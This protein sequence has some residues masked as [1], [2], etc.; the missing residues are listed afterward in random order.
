MPS[1]PV[2]S[3]VCVGNIMWGSKFKLYVHL[4][5]RRI[6]LENFWKSPCLGPITRDFDTIFLLKWFYH[7]A[8][9]KKCWV[10]KHL[11]NDHAVPD[12][13]LSTS[14][15]VYQTAELGSPHLRCHSLE[16]W[17]AGESASFGLWSFPNEVLPNYVSLRGTLSNEI[18]NG[19]ICPSQKKVL[20]LRNGSWLTS[21]IK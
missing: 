14:L 10:L 7:T 2:T 4:A 16:R 15:S 17:V 20:V 1:C 8:E 9:A 18:A 5:T 11:H 13:D 19:S 12:T 3:M 21:R 6:H